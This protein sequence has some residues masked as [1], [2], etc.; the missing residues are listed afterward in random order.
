VAIESEI[1]TLRP[2][3]AITAAACSANSRDMNRASYPTTTP[4]FRFLC[5]AK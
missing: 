1:F 2:A 3:L 4:F 5:F